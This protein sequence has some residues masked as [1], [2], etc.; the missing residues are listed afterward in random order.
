M[1]LIQLLLPL[2]DNEENRL[3][4]ALFAEVREELVE[5]FGGLT[6]HTR[7]PAS[8]VWKDEHDQ[9]Q[10][11]DIVIYEVMAEE[12]DAGWWKEYRRSMAVRFGQEEL[13]ARALQV[14]VL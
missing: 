7:A 2:Y 9:P 4:V 8:G 13:M 11:D 12:L 5:R 10:R 6:A 14:T 3:P 1:H